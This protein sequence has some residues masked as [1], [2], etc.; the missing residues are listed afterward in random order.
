MFPLVC[1]CVCRYYLGPNLLPSVQHRLLKA[2][3]MNDI[4]TRQLFKAGQIKQLCVAAV[5]CSPLEHRSLL[6]QVRHWTA[7]VRPTGPAP[8]HIEAVSRCPCMLL[9]FC[10]G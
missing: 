4:L 3:L 8:V 5:H 9:G 6:R 1:V 10:A 2:S 7:V